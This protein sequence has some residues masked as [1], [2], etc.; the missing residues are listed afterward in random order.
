MR[1]DKC[2]ISR[3]KQGQKDEVQSFPGSWKEAERYI[4]RIT[5]Q[6][7]P[8]HAWFWVLTASLQK[9]KPSTWNLH[10]NSSTQFLEEN[11]R[12]QTTASSRNRMFRSF[13]LFSLL[14]SLFWE[15]G[16]CLSREPMCSM[17]FFSCFGWEGV[18]FS[19]YAWL[20]WFRVR[21]Y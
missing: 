16:G 13:F 9:P 21:M 1:K 11:K 10:S 14:F 15:M 6:E 7:L 12:S 3:R 2:S 8:P 20:A 17:W 18:S 4:P 5:S 19:I